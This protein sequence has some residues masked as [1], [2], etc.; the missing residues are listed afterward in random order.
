MRWRVEEMATGVE[1]KRRFRGGGPG[2][3]GNSSYPETAGS[4]L[5]ASIMDRAGVEPAGG[6]DAERASEDAS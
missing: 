4:L 5:A 3:E 6:A 2:T 1:G